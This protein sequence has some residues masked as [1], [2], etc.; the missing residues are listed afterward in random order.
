MALDSFQGNLQDKSAVN[1]YLAR[2]YRHYIDKMLFIG[3]GAS[4]M[5][6]TKFHYTFWDLVEKREDFAG[7]VNAMYDF[8]KQDKATM[9]VQERYDKVMPAGIDWC[10]SLSDSVVVCDDGKRNW[11]YT[12]QAQ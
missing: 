4:T 10:T 5:T 1:R 8:L 2:S 7:R 12:R 9:A 11:V 3:L 6:Y